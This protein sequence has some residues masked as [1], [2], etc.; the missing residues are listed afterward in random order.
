[1]YRKKEAILII[2]M[3]FFV[4]MILVFLYY[5]TPKKVEK[6][7]NI[8]F[9]LE[10]PIQIHIEGEIDRYVDLV[11]VKPISYATL[12]MKL[13][14]LINEFSDISSF[15]M[16]EMIYESCSIII[17][18]KDRNNQFTPS[19]KIDIHHASSDDLM[20]LPQIG[21]KRA[22][23]ILDYIALYGYID[24]WETFFKIASIPNHAQDQIKQQA[25]L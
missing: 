11:Y 7:E 5:K 2:L 10:E 8:I 23:K 4:L 24:S 20:K 19:E 21:E 13:S 6:E 1:M 15:A 22:K 16:E 9:S 12:F 14:I 18:T 25:F 17:P 3:F